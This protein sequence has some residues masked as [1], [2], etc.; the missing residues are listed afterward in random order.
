MVKNVQDY[1]PYL[2]KTKNGKPRDPKT[3]KVRDVMFIN[4]SDLS[5]DQVTLDIGNESKPFTMGIP[6][7]N[8]KTFVISETEIKP[9]DWVLTINNLDKVIEKAF[10]VIRFTLN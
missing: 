10:M 2:V 7:G 6:V 9:S 1:L 4:Q 3:I 5:I 8:T